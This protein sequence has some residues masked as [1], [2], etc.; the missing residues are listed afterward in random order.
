MFIVTNRQVVQDAKG[1]DK[2]GSKPNAEGPNELR[3]V[4]A[5]KRNKRWVIKILPDKLDDAMMKEVSLAPTIGPDGK[6]Q[7]VYASQYV[8]RKI[9]DRT[10]PRQAGKKGKNL[11][12]FVHGFN[13]DFKAVL[14]RMDGLARTYN[15]EVIGFSWPANGGGIG[16]V[17]DYKSDKRDARAS[18]GALDRFLA[19]MYDLL[20]AFNK[21][22]LDEITA[23]ARTKF[24]SAERRDEFIAREAQKGCPFTVNLVLHSMG[25]YLFKQVLASSVYRGTR[26][27]FDN[28]VMAAADTNNKGHASWVDRIHCRQRLYITINE[29][30]AAL[31]ASRI[32]SGEEQ[33]ARLGHY[34]HNLYSKQ[35]MYVDFTEAPRVGSSHAYFEG[36]PIRNKKSTAVKTFFQRAFN[37]ERAEVDLYY[38][39]DS[40]MYRFRKPK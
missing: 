21:A 32:K 25:N 36:S 4:E 8:A 10:N 3:L 40:H 28:V 34:P 23:K 35:A 12:V 7:P 14:E 1:F 37:G 17:L 16:G 2:L 9:L 27:L 15:V 18:V 6:P 19:R 22:Y 30:D 11:L 24:A 39:P 20:N 5:T 29:N 38:H 26:L 33:L 31:K 13:N